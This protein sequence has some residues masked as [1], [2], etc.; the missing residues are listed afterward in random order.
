MYKVTPKLLVEAWA[1][2]LPWNFFELNIEA[3]VNML[4]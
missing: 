2:T 4:C 1:L 3:L